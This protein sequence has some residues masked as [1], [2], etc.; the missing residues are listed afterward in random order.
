MSSRHWS[1]VCMRRDEAIRIISV[2]RARREEIDHY[3]GG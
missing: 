2:R 1:E 3:E